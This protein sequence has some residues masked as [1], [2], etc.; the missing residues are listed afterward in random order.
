MKQSGPRYIPPEIIKRCFFDDII[1]NFANN[2]INNNLKPSQ[3]S[4]IDI[5]M[6]PKTGEL[7]DTGNYRWIV[8]H[9]WWQ[10]W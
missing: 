7:S 6:L 2:L 4:E 8:Y 5:I 3:W 1:L 9:S 10:S